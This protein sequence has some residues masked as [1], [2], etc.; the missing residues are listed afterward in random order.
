LDVTVDAD[1]GLDFRWTN[2]TDTYVLIQAEADDERVYFGLYGTKPSWKVEVGEAVISNRTPPDPKP[3]AQ[4]EPSLAWGRT[5]QVETARDGFDA[6]V[7]RRVIPTDGGAPRELNLKSTYQPAHTVTLVGTAGKPA[8]IKI[9]D[10]LQRVLDAQKPT[11]TPAPVQAT[12]AAVSAGTPGAA[13]TPAAGGTR[14]A[15][16]QPTPAQATTSA[17]KPTVA[18]T[19]AAAVRTPAPKPT[20]AAA[21]QAT[22]TRA[23]R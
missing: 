23:P 12:P 3:I 22:P 8:G 6:Q 1:A 19:A 9:E 21:V 10:V 14:V 5:L 20:T 7:T 11:P 15:P 4:E 13:A 17:A 16:A 18:P 2:T